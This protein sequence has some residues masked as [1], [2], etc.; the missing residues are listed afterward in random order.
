MVVVMLMQKEVLHL[1]VDRVVKRK[2]S[3]RTTQRIAAAKGA[4]QQVPLNREH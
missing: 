4:G 3:T 2:G 1:T